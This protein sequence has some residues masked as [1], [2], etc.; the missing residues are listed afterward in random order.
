MSYFTIDDAIC[1]ITELGP[2]TELA[3]IDVKGAF[4]LIPV[5]PLDCNLLAMEW[6]GGIYI[7]TCLPFGL[8]STPKLFNLMADFLEWILQE[9]GV[10]YLLH[11]L[12]D[13]LTLGYPGSQEC[14]N[15]LQAILTTCKILGVPLALER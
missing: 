6:K 9:Q 7:D 3:K 15:N 5:N 14:C 11:Y 8:H 12:D 13:Y 4:C 1:K 2:G 10:T